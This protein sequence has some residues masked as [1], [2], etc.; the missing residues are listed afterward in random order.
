MATDSER[1][2]KEGIEDVAELQ[3]VPKVRVNPPGLGSLDAFASDSIPKL[4]QGMEEYFAS[5][6]G[7]EQ[8]GKLIHMTY[9]KLYEVKQREGLVAGGDQ[10]SFH[11]QMQDPRCDFGAMQE[12]ELRDIIVK[13]HQG[14]GEHLLNQCTKQE[15]YKMAKESFESKPFIH[16][17][18]GCFA[19]RFAG[20]EFELAD[21][22]TEFKLAHS[23][24]GAPELDVFWRSVHGDI[25]L[26][27]FPRVVRVNDADCAGGTH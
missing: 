26:S 9:A 2:W 21:G 13:R 16:K 20:Q 8:M 3:S 5:N 10:V 18:E 1:L 15:L 4:R 25:S 23:R 19:Y 24:P 12:E 17:F 7:K 27:G 11:I 6:L 14:L 22:K